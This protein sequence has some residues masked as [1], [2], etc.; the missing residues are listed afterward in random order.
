AAYS[1]AGTGFVDPSAGT[2]PGYAAMGVDVIPAGLTD[3][4]VPIPSEIVARIRV[5]GDD[6]GGQTIKSSELDFPISLCNGCLVQYPPDAASTTAPAGQ[7]ICASQSTTSTTSTGIAPCR[8]GQDVVFS[9]ALCAATSA[10]CQNPV[11]NP[12]YKAPV[13]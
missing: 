8:L 7:Y 12:A 1:T 2:A 5:F 9:C 6:L 3:L 4:N 11:N 10:V 13:P